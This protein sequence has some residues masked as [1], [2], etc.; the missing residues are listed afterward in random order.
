MGNGDLSN[1]RLI[2]FSQ[3]ATSR[4]SSKTFCIAKNDLY[5][6][7]EDFMELRVCVSV[8]AQTEEGQGSKTIKVSL[9][10]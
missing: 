9:S 8:Y 4:F 10:R 6:P 2:T 3:K 7:V 5:L 1:P